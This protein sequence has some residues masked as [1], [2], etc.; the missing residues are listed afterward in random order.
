MGELF[1]NKAFI[2]GEKGTREDVLGFFESLSN[3]VPDESPREFRR[4]Q[5][6]PKIIT[7]AVTFKV[8]HDSPP[9]IKTMFY[10]YL[11]TN[12]NEDL[13]SLGVEF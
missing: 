1:G 7:S 2:E 5:R 10:G 9:D 6:V 12:T 11:S 8:I 3:T 13:K 4:G